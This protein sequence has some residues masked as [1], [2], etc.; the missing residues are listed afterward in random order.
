MSPMTAPGSRRPE[1]T[2]SSSASSGVDCGAVFDCGSATVLAASTIEVTT[3]EMVV[4]GFRADR[5]ERCVIRTL[6]QG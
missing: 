5:S 1:T 4:V 2:T 3:V 6:S